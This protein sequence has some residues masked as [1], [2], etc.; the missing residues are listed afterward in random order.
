VLLEARASALGDPVILRGIA[1]SLSEISQFGFSL[2]V[3]KELRQREPDDS[4]VWL[5]F[6]SAKCKLARDNFDFSDIVRELDQLQDTRKLE[7]GQRVEA[8]V[9]Y[10]KCRDLKSAIK[11]M[12]EPKALYTDYRIGLRLARLHS[13]TRERRRAA[14]ELKRVLTAREIPKSILHECGILSRKRLREGTS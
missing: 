11:V 6:L 7:M 13:F 8:L 5:G 10:Q 2:D 4:A 1:V 3:W 14:R 9:L 12:Q